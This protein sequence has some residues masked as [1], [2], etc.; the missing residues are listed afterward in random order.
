MY[1]IQSGGG[2]LLY[3]VPFR[4]AKLSLRVIFHYSVSAC[5]SVSLS[6]TCHNSKPIVRKLYQVVEVVSTEKPFDFEVKGQ[7]SS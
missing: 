4:F 6:P 3:R 7:R 1:T 2:M 5:L